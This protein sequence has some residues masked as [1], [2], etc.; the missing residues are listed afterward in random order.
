MNEVNDKPAQQMRAK[1]TI[2]RLLS[3]TLN[4]IKSA[5]WAGTSMPKICDAAEVARGAQT[6]HFPT[7]ADLMMAAL[8]K[9]ASDHE[10]EIVGQVSAI[11]E[12][13]RSLKKV[14]RAIWNA[15]ADDQFMQPSIEAMVA[16]R[17]DESLH[18]HV[19]PRDTE[20]I[21]AMRALAAKVEAPGLSDAQIANIIE[22]S[23]YLFRGIAI[24][25]G[26]HNDEKYR[27]GLFDV[28]VELILARA[29]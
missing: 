19:A 18:N 20:A 17:T 16:A 26:M 28:W 12:G 24:E 15:C 22:L 4:G 3:A 10:T 11:P 1:E 21:D 25:R 7:K 14:L 23:I 13:K 27:S 6:H 29:S 2:E 8:Q 9:T 5:G